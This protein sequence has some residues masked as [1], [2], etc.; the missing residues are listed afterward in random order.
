LGVRV[1]C[2]SNGIAVARPSTLSF[3]ISLE[4]FLDKWI[5]F[6][7]LFFDSRATAKAFAEPLERLPAETPNMR[8]R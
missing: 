8:Q 4:G 5:D 6:Y 3:C 1:N 2:D 7:E